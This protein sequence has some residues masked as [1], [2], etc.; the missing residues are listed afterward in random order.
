MELFVLAL[1]VVAH[2]LF[3]VALQA[4]FFVAQALLS[5]LL[6][7]SLLN[8][9]GQ[10]ASVL[11]NAF[12]FKPNPHWDQTR[13]SWATRIVHMALSAEHK[14]EIGK[15]L[16]Q[17]EQGNLA[18]SMTDVVAYLLQHHLAYRQQVN[19]RD[20]GVH[21]ENRDGMGLDV[22]HVQ[23]LVS[24]INSLG[25]VSSEAKGIAIEIPSNARGTQM[26]AFNE[27]LVRD[28]EGKLGGGNMSLLRYASLEGSHANQASRAVLHKALHSDPDATVNGRLSMDKISPEWAASIRDGH[29]WI[30]VR[31]E[32]EDAFPQYPALQQS[33]G[34]SVQQVSKNEDDLQIAKKMAKA[35]EVRLRT[36]KGCQYSDIA[37]DILR[38]RPKATAF[39]SIFSFVMKCGGGGAGHASAGGREFLSESESFI[40][41]HGAPGR[42]LGQ[43]FWDALSQ[44][45]KGSPRIVWRHML[46]KCAFC[47]PERTMTPNDV[48]GWKIV[49]YIKFVVFVFLGMR[50]LEMIWLR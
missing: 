25:F 13:V 47:C 16:L 19:C 17:A 48:T 10:L 27:K 20:I 1:F 22:A 15:L 4:L 6:L 49:F 9:L 45:T 31:A 30:I 36:H 3:L 41:T 44:E 2:A 50:S 40:R 12:W 11:L 26:K 18:S 8:L 38:S 39:A 7:E 29:Q 32:V 5:L 43:E 34:N 23:S 33:A 24:S 37:G 28:A 42:A 35:I 14:H 21:P 46:L